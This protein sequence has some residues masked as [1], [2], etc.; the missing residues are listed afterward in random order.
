M[1]NGVPEL[2]AAP[3]TGLVFALAPNK[4]KP[5]K[6]ILLHLVF[7]GAAALAVAAAPM[8]GPDVAPGI[9]WNSFGGKSADMVRAEG[10]LYTL[11][12]IVALPGAPR[13]N[14]YWRWWESPYLGC[15]DGPGGTHYPVVVMGQSPPP[16]SGGAPAIPV[17]EGGTTTV[18][19]G[20]GVLIFGRV[21]RR[22]SG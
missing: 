8:G 4:D 14:L 12:N 16:P 5:M 17:S 11:G 3:E 19:L 7:M 18:L 2:Q 20:I 10:R 1:S 21:R 6:K 15:G 13:A 9:A 22:I